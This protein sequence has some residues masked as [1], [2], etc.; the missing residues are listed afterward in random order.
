MELKY[1]KI[2]KYHIRFAMEENRTHRIL[3]FPLTPCKNAPFPLLPLAEIGKRTSET[4][5]KIADLPLYTGW[6]SAMVYEKVYE[7]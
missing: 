7:L 3:E 6:E 5:R 2:S 1:R 4:S